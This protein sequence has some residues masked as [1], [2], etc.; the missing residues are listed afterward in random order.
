M[1][2]VLIVDFGI[3]LFG[4]RAFIKIRVRIMNRLLVSICSIWYGSFVLFSV[5]LGLRFE[6]SGRG[7]VLI[8]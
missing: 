7:V 5:S 2:V 8:R 1:F 4:G 3:F 6:V